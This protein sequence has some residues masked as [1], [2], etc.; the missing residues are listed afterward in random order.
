[1]YGNSWGWQSCTAVSA[2]TK[3]RRETQPDQGRMLYRLRTE[4]NRLAFSEELSTWSVCKNKAGPPPES[5]DPFRPRLQRVTRTS[6]FQGKIENSAVQVP[7][8][9]FSFTKYSFSS[10]LLQKRLEIMHNIKPKQ[11]AIQDTK[12]PPKNAIFMQNSENRKT[13]VIKLNRKMSISS[14]G[15]FNSACCSGRFPVMIVQ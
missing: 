3:D 15:C 13:D 4:S 5:N 2:D 14:A 1:M 7:K 8:Y 6:N 10:F 12:P 9:D 11:S